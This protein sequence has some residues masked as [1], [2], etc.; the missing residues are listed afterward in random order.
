MP[1]GYPRPPPLRGPGTRAAQRG[2]RHHEADALRPQG[3]PDAPFPRRR[4]RRRPDR[5]PAVSSS[6]PPGRRRRTRPAGIPASVR[7]CPSRAAPWCGRATAA[8]GRR[9]PRTPCCFPATASRRA[10]AARTPSRC[11]SSATAR[12]SSGPTR[13]SSCRSEATVRVLAGRGRGARDPARDADRGP[14]SG[15]LRAAGE[16]D[17]ARPRRGHGDH[18]ARRRAALAHGLPREH[19]QR[20]DG[21]APRQR[22]R[23][24]RAARRGLP[25]GDGRHP[26]PDRAHDGRA[27]VR[28]L[29]GPAAR[30]RL[31]LPA[32]GRRVDQRLRHVDRQRARRGRHRREGARAADLRGHPAAQEGPGPA[33]VAGRQPLQGARVPDRAA[34]GEAHAPALHAGAPPRGAD[35]AL[36]L[37]A[38]QR[39]PAQQAAA[40]SRRAGERRLVPAHDGGRVPEPRVRDR[41][42]GAR[43][44]RPASRSTPRTT[45]PRATSRWPSTLEPSAG[46]SAVTHRRGD[47][48]TSCSCSPRPPARARAG[49]ASWCPRASRSTCSWSPTPPARWTRRHATRRPPSWTGLLELLGPDDRFRLLAADVDVHAAFDGRAARPAEDAGGR[50]APSSTAASRWAG[51]TSTPR[52]RA[53]W[54]RPATARSS[55]TSATASPRRATPIPSPRPSGSARRVAADEGHGARRGDLVDLRA[56]RARGARLDR[57]RLRPPRGRRTRPPRPTACWPR[58]RG[59]CFANAK[60]EIRGHPDRARVPGD[61]AQPARRAAQQVVLGRFLPGDGRGE[62]ARSS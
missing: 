27:V 47:E 13:S 34:L 7:S 35:L 51:P 5:A 3:D 30:G 14:R 33:R 32:A 46:L 17:G 9:W 24:Q 19:R 23:P 53:C 21:L 10:R 59:R 42:H 6:R 41:H 12:S 4:S 55:S 20:V 39:S 18:R 48:G 54:A 38:A 31:L 26:R 60:V 28:Q 11:S 43:A 15:R 56:G 58:W 57:R 2:P 62:P 40:A 49:R 61:A 25:Q 29:D 37:R 8:A 50:R 22:R 16:R 36:P 44:P 52:W 45:C 1:S